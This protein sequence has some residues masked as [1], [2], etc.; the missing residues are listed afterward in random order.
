MF[1]LNGGLV[2]GNEG[3][4]TV[5]GNSSPPT[6][7]F[8]GL[9]NDSIG[10]TPQNPINLFVGGEGA[11]TISTTN[12]DTRATIYGGVD[13]TRAA[14]PTAPTLVDCFP[15]ICDDFSK[16]GAH[17]IPQMSYR[18]HQCRLPILP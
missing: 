3:N 11:D 18:S 15:P 10:F 8:G 4:D 16:A 13:S 5:V 17:Q 9:G 7:V 12:P 6:T 1:V 14:A 2:F